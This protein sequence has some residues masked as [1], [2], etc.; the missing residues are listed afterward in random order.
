MWLGDALLLA[1]KELTE[2]PGST[3]PAVL[4]VTELSAD[5]SSW[6]SPHETDLTG[7]GLVGVAGLVVLP[8]YGSI[9]GGEVNTW[10][11]AYPRGGILD[12]DTGAWSELPEARLA[13]A[14][15]RLPNVVVGDRVVVVGGLLD[16]VA[17][18]WVAL[19]ELPTDAAELAVAASTDTLFVW[20]GALRDD[21]P[22]DEGYLLTPGA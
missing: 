17:G 9:N 8:E 6:S 3:E 10:D 20:G 13:P 22:S 7:W 4:R 2:S 5:L 16:P 12:P 19:P 15:G 14:W 18:T 21:G 11:R 1:A